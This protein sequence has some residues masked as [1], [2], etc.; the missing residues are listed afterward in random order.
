MHSKRFLFWCKHFDSI[1]H[2]KM[3]LRWRHIFNNSIYS[4]F[5]KTLTVGRIRCSPKLTV[6]RHEKWYSDIVFQIMFLFMARIRS[7]WFRRDSKIE[8]GIRICGFSGSLWKSCKRFCCKFRFFKFSAN[9]FEM[10]HWSVIWCFCCDG[11]K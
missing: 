11:K 9:N 5:I 7:A 1:K 2:A 10:S 6:I 8:T 3:Q 4:L